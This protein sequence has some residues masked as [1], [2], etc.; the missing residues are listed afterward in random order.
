MGNQQAGG[1]M[2]PFNDPRRK[3]EDRKKE[4]GNHVS[5]S[6]HKFKLN[7]SYSSGKRKVEAPPQRVGRKKKKKG[8]EAATKLPTGMLIRNL[9]PCY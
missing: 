7:F 2:N 5:L 6:F 4:E 3:K 8:A 9:N 1:G